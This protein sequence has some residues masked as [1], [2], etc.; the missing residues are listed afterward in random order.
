MLFNK[1]SI[2][3][4]NYYSNHVSLSSIFIKVILYSLKVGSL[5]ADHA[6]VSNQTNSH[7]NVIA[8]VDNL[9]N[10]GSTVMIQ[11]VSA[12][13]ASASITSG[14]NIANVSQST[15][16][17]SSFNQVFDC[18]TNQ[19]CAIN[20]TNNVPYCAPLQSTDN[21]ELIVVLGVGI[22][23]FFIIVGL[24]IVLCVYNNKRKKTKDMEDELDNKKNGRVRR[25]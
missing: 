25:R 1:T 6:V 16:A 10:G 3:L 14:T 18:P 17:C 21:F 12:G 20:S 8:A 11:G 2:A 4:T 19:G 9:V 15:T 24:I 13:A 23:L 22:T 5:I 7:P